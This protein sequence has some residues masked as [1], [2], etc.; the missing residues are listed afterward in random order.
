M[1][2]KLRDDHLL[3]T[4]QAAPTFPTPPHGLAPE[5]YPKCFKFMSVKLRGAHPRN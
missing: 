4:I 5:R 3:L 2:G 1:P